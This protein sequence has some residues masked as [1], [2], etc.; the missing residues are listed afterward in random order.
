M[1][2]IKLV[3]RKA[4]KKLNRK[5]VKLNFYFDD[6]YGKI[7]LVNRNLNVKVRRSQKFLVAIYCRQVDDIGK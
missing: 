6:I 5:C 7:L 4:I 1:K 2:F 3:I